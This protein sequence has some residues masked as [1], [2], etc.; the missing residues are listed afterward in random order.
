M[1][2]DPEIRGKG[3]EFAFPVR[4]QGQGS[5]DEERLSAGRCGLFHSPSPPFHS[6]GQNPRNGLHRLAEAHVIGKQGTETV[7]GH[8]A[9][10]GQALRLIGTQRARKSVRPDPAQRLARPD[11]APSGRPEFVDQAPDPAMRLQ[12]L[13]LERA[14]M[15]DAHRKR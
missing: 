6:L 1:H 10:P 5:D 12:L 3:G 13:D 9:K 4:K 11:R 15:P 14:D 8:E 2:V 7:T